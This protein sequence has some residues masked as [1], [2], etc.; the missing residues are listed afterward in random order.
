MRH[1]VNALGEGVNVFG[2][3]GEGGDDEVVHG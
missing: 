1:E 2:G 3:F